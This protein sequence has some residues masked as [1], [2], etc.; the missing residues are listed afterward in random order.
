MTLHQLAGGPGWGVCRAHG[1]VLGSRE[2]PCWQPP[3]PDPPAA[4]SAELHSKLQSSEAEVRG[5]CEELR[6]LHGQLDEAQAQNSQLTERIRSIEALL[7]ASQTR[8]TQVS[9]PLP[10]PLHP[11]H[12][13][14]PQP[15]DLPSEVCLL[16]TM[17]LFS[18]SRPVEWRPT[19][20]RPGKRGQGPSWV[21]DPGKDP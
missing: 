6:G 16:V 3:T 15:D 14:A 17:G 20:S 4:P 2:H 7:E 10:G 12:P 5:K 13:W 11:T 9:S 21:W 1:C 18:R 8:D 19:S